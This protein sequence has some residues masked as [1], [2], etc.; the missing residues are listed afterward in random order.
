MIFVP[1]IW[2]CFD[3]C[4]CKRKSLKNIPVN[5]FLF[6]KGPWPHVFED[7]AWDLPRGSC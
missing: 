6:E 2:A 4:P 3:F 7:M 1:V 5:F